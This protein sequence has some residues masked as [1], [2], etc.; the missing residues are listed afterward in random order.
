MPSAASESLHHHPLQLGSC[1]I[2][3]DCQSRES[4]YDGASCTRYFEI[5]ASCSHR[6]DLG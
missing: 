5:Q 3:N 6:R 1:C 4:G 2:K